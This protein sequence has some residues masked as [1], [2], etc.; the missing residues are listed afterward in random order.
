MQ[1]QAPI[2][3]SFAEIEF[4]FWLAQQSAGSEPAFA[5]GLLALPKTHSLPTA[6]P[7][8]SARAVAVVS[9]ARQS[10]E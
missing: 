5:S 8:N 7:D 2:V 6:A 9:S 1:Q 4:V 10:V 3:A